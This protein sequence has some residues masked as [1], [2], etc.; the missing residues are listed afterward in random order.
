MR[1][2]LKGLDLTDEVV[3]SIMAEHGKAIT[4]LKEQNESY[5]GKISEYEDTIKDLN[6]TIETNNK[7]LENLQNVTSENDDLKIQLQMN[8]S[9]VKKEFSKFVTSEIKSLVDDENDF[10]TVLEYYKEENPQ[11]FGDTPMQTIQT[12]ESLNLGGSVPQST[13]DIMNGILRSAANDD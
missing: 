7:A 13:N 5:K 10:Q 4:N 6:A 1:E 12:S 3:E 9:H 8:D 2:F 11:Y